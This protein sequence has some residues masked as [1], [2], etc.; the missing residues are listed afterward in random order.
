[1]LKRPEGPRSG[2][3]ARRAVCEGKFGLVRY[4]SWRTAL[5]SKRCVDRFGAGRAR[6]RN[7][8]PWL[9]IAFGQ[10]QESRARPL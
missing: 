2:R 5:C 3:A 10:A 6:G 7:W 4:H 1:M 8:L 9:Q